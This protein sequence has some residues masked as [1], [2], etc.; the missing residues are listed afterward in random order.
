MSRTYLI[1]TEPRSTSASLQDGL[2]ARVADPLWMLGRQWQVG[3][4]LGE[5]SGSPV[6]VDLAA[7]TAM[8]SRFGHVGR[9]ATMPYDPA[10]VPLDVLT[11]DPVRT[12]E[13]W[14]A[15]LRVDTGRAFLRF[16]GEAGLA[17]YAA[18][19][20]AEHPLNPATNALRAADPGGARM[21]DV[22]SGRI[23]DGQAL[24]AALRAPIR[25]GT[26]LPAAPVIAAG[27]IDGVRKALAAWLSFCDSTIAETGPST[28]LPDQLSHGFSIATGSAP[29]AA[30]LD[31]DG[32]LGDSLDWHSF[33]ARPIAAPTGFTPLPPGAA[34][35]AGVR[36]RGMPNARWWEF[37]DASVDLGSVD[38]GA[39]D[40]ARLALLEF[41][42]V[43]ANDFFAV[44]VQLPIGSVCRITSLI[45]SDTFGMRMRIQPSGRGPRQGSSRWTIFTLSER[46][47]G[48]LANGVSDLFF[49]PPIA[50]QTITGPPVED[51]LLLRDEM[52]NLAWAV[53]RRHEGEGGRGIDAIEELTRAMPE[54]MAPGA[55][56]TLRYLLGTAV[57]P[58]WFPLVPQAGAAGVELKLEQLTNRDDSVKPRGRFLSL[59]GPPIPDGTV[60]REGTQLL[61]DYAMA[62]WT[63]GA[64][65]TWA[66]RIRRVGRGEGSSSL[67]FD[68]VEL[69]SGVV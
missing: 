9:A 27:D 41:A 26:D 44:P 32:Y 59:D 55:N 17:S 42:L 38:A 10:A 1:R 65:F 4:L 57:P 28:W 21:L 20:R 25:D 23:P 2:A 60:P 68:V 45:V 31:A 22:T 53:E 14:T 67:R 29:S 8:I 7:E 12:Q 15:R 33:D 66:R 35:P 51:V 58:Y 18:G 36:F 47:P 13:P 48:E 40:V 54:R 46:E 30:V 63:N 56:A 50:I 64:S 24:D 5:D 61:R 16:L 34:I 69:D 52:A 3:E 49:L 39:S 6:S 19:F 11:G 43:Y 62:R 37:E